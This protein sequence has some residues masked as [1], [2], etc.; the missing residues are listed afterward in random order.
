MKYTFTF[1]FALCAA[2]SFGQQ[3]VLEDFEGSPTVSGFEGLGGATIEAA[4][5]GT[6]T[7]SFKLVTST[8][9][10]GKA[11]QGAQIDLASGSYADL[12]TD[13]TM[14]ID[15]Y[16]TT[17][18][19][20]TA[21][22]EDKVANTAPAAANTQAHAGA[23]WQTLTF[24]FNTGSDGTAT[25][26]GVYTRVAFFPNRN[27]ADTGWN[28]PVANVTMYA[29][30]ITAVKHVAAGPTCSDGIMNGDE[31]GVD[32]GGTS[33]SP[34]P[35]PP[36][37][38]PTAPPARAVADVLS[39]YGEAYGTAVGLTN[40][41]WDAA[42]FT[43]E[44]IAGNKV[45]KA[46][47]S[48]SA[49]FGADLNTQPTDAS[50]MTHFNVD[51]WVADAYVIG[52]VLDAKW[53]NHAGGAG[54]TSVFLKSEAL[55]ATDV[56]SWKSIDVEISTLTNTTRDELWQFTVTAANST[57]SAS[58]VYIDN[59]YFYKIPTASVGELSSS[60]SIYPNPMGSLLTV[61]GVSEVQHASIFD[62][63]GR[64]VLSAMP[65]KAVFTLDT[66]D[67]QHG[68]YM[69]SLQIGDTKTTHKL[70]K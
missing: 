49:F 27:A 57:G 10:T 42:D 11:W 34:C 61:E 30:N 47:L 22:V 62:L 51:Y 67:L 26:N 66:A 31:T 64:E 13:K 65:N 53:S 41:T 33:C 45:L 2:V 19:S 14:K 39:I 43:E 50:A 17:A 21:K 44:T 9:S 5:S 8:S 56:Q 1:L 54:E 60:F 59:V 12:T 36:T 58:L 63:T 69:L 70:V 20:L 6:N 28:S 25:A 38:A 29:D 32:C 37:T 3:S 46:D 55:G 52:Q 18:F 24:T 16:S 23:G 15:V 48:G 7:N 40:V 4:P 68:V 35:V